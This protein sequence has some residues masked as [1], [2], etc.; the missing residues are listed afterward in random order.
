MRISD[1]SSDVCS[2]DLQ[3]D[4]HPF[5][6]LLQERCRVEIGLPDIAAHD[7]K[8][9]RRSGLPVDD[10]SAASVEANRIGPAQLAQCLDV[11]ADRIDRDQCREA[12]DDFADLLPPRD[13]ADDAG[14]GGPAAPSERFGIAART[15]DPVGR[16]SVPDA[17]DIYT[18]GQTLVGR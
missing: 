12:I 1:W 11:A 17:S 18:V 4:A 7:Q 13:L 10:A 14:V 15:P 8:A 2:S 9:I 6:I 3:I 16:L 5:F